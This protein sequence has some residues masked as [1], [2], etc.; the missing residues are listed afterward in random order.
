MRNNRVISALATEE[1]HEAYDDVPD[2]FPAYEKPDF[3]PETVGNITRID[4]SYLKR[5]KSGHKLIFVD[6][7]M[8]RVGNQ[9][10]FGYS[11][12]RCTACGEVKTG[13]PNRLHVINA[14]NAMLGNT[15]S[16]TIIASGS[17][18]YLDK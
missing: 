16:I 10:Y 14:Y 15:N 3:Y 11:Q 5:C 4:L 6:D 12:Y 9:K 17:G 18:I 13:L 8:V 7:M 1:V 2:F